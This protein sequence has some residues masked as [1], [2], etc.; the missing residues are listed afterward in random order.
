[1]EYASATLGSLETRV[2]V[3]ILELSAECSLNARELNDYIII[4]QY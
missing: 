3:T 4:I 2:N 1:M